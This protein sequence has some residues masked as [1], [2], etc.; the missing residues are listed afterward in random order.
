MSG[1]CLA[2]LGNEVLC[3][4]IDPEKI[5]QLNKGNISLYEPGLE[6]IIHRNIAAKQLNFSAHAP[7]GAAHGLI[8]IIAV[9]TPA[10]TDGSADL[11]YV[12]ATVQTGL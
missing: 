1:A 10:D 2:E 6:K 12:L 11:Q 3:V 9:G 8:Q 7:D 5:A 4:D